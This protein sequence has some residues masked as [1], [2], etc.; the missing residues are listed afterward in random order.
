MANAL[1]GSLVSVGDW[2]RGHNFEGF[3]DDLIDWGE[4]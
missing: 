4:F 3:V 1:F 2:T